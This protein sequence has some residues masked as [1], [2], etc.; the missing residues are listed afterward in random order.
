MVM[1]LPTAIIMKST[2]LDIRHPID[3]FHMTHLSTL[4]FL[5]FYY[6]DT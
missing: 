1:L 2:N 5:D 6:S 3:L 4:S